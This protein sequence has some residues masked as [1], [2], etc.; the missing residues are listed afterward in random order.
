MRLVNHLEHLRWHGASDFDV[1]VQALFRANDV[2]LL[3]C[4]VQPVIAIDRANALVFGFFNL[5][6]KTARVEIAER[7]L[8]KSP[9][10][11]QLSFKQGTADIVTELYEV[12]TLKFRGNTIDLVERGAAVPGNHFF[13]D[14]QR[15]LPAHRIRE[16]VARVLFDYKTNEGEYQSMAF[17]LFQRVSVHHGLGG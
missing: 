3:A 16:G 17:V 2:G 14:E 13:F 6:N 7:H 5:S 12:H 8:G 10:R 1:L 9:F 15:V 4:P 11:Y